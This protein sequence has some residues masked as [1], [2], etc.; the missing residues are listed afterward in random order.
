MTGD[1][2]QSYDFY[3]K[4]IRLSQFNSDVI[5]KA[6]DSF[7]MVSENNYSDK[8]LNEVNKAKPKYQSS[9]KVPLVRKSNLMIA[10]KNSNN[11][12]VTTEIKNLKS[13]KNNEIDELF[14]WAS[15][16]NSRINKIE[17]KIKDNFNRYV[18][19]NDNIQVN[20]NF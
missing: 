3:L 4:A 17:V 15:N 14:K 19:A 10:R 1:Y 11:P 13:E 18:V 8:I 7:E 2:S 12:S 5:Y 16:H 6:I 20:N 9:I